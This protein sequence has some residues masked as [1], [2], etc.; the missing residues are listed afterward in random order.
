MNDNARNRRRGLAVSSEATA[1]AACGRAVCG[2][3]DPVYAGLCPAEEN[4]AGVPTGEMPAAR[5]NGA[6]IQP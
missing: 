4:A 2:H 6:A 5:P 1:C 3:P